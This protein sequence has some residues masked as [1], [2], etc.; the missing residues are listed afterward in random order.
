MIGLVAPDSISAA[1]R[2]AMNEAKGTESLTLLLA[3]PEFQ[4]R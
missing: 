2:A 1:T 3:A 4:R